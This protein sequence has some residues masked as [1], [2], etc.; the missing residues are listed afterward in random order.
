MAYTSIQTA[1]WASGGGVQV[2]YDKAFKWA[3]MGTLVCYPLIDVEPEDETSQGSSIT[4]YKQAY[5]SETDIANATT[6]LTEESDVTPIKLP[7]PAS[8]TLTPAEYGVAVVRT[9][10]L[11]LRNL[12]RVDPIIAKAVARHAA[13]TLD[14][15]VQTEL[16]AGTE[17]VRAAGRASTVTIANGDLLT[18]ANVRKA[19]T[20]LRGKNVEPRDGR[21]MFLSV[22][23][24]YVIHDLRQETGSGSWRVPQE[25]GTDQG[26]IYRGEFGEFEGARY[27]QTTSTYRSTDTDGAASEPVYRGFMLG[28]EALAKKELLPATAVVSPVTDLLKRF[29]GVGWKAD[30]DFGIYR[31]E[32]LVRFESATSL[33]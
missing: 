29:M 25:Y 10:K 15:L 1:G 18:A 14:R 30:L 20:L 31:D 11:S 3:L 7:A 13:E 21:G 4:M 19:V 26:R 22:M 23:H 2:A 5:F 8:V 32:A 24:P 9:Q 33:T 27:I 6:P 16:R 12:T 28:Q 17:V